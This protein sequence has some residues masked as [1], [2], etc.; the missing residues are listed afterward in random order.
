MS[1][2]IYIALLD[3][4]DRWLKEKVELQVRAMEEPGIGLVY[5]KGYHVT[6]DENGAVFSK[7]PYNMS[8]CFLAEAGFKDLLYGDYIGTTS[9]AMIRRD[10][11]AVCGL[12]DPEQ[13]AR[14]DYE[15]WIRVSRHYRCIGVTEF[16]FEHVQHTQ[17]QITK[18]RQKALDGIRR[19]YAKYRTY[20]GYT[21]RCHFQLI[22]AKLCMKDKIV[23]IGLYHG[24]AGSL[25]L[26]LALL[27]DRKELRL[28]NSLHL[29]RI[30]YTDI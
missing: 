28:R 8:S 22:M 13:P 1:R 24:L 23:L 17:E 14:Q 2:G 18:S 7:R 20:A 16:L 3:D 12:F 25:Y 11:F 15:M 9:Q 30:R 21:C 10:V 6:L 5:C 29:Q 4:D 19:V 26:L 27:F